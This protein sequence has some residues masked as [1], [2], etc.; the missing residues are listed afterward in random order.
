[1]A[2]LPVGAK[3]AGEVA[4]IGG[5]TCVYNCVIDGVTRYVEITDDVVKRGQAHLRQ[6]GITIDRIEGLQNLSRADARA[7]EQTL[8]DYHG[9]GKD[10]GT[11]I[12]KIN[13]ISS[14]KNPTKYEQGLIR[15]A[16][17]LKKAGYEGF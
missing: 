13:S 2:R 17:L 7:V 5:K 12:N 4:S 11:L 9:L 6:K 16:E 8:I 10:G 3:G 1:M 14:V 15:G